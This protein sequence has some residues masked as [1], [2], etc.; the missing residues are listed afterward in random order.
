[1]ELAWNIMQLRVLYICKS[2]HTSTS[3]NHYVNVHILYTI[4]LLCEL[5][6]VHCTIFSKLLH[7]N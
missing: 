5:Y 4:Y 6:C 2:K 7:T 1:M 3:I